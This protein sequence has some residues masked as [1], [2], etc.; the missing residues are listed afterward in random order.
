MLRITVIMVIRSLVLVAKTSNSRG[1]VNQEIYVIFMKN[2]EVVKMEMVCLLSQVVLGENWMYSVFW[3]NQLKTKLEYDQKKL[4]RS[5][6]KNSMFIAEL[7][8]G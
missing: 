2:V 5:V 1:R 8:F 6:I 3:M 7:F 4:R